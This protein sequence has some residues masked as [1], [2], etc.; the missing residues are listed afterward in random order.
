MVQNKKEKKKGNLDVAAHI[1]SKKKNNKKIKGQ[2]QLCESSG[3]AA[4]STCVSARKELLCIFKHA[5]DM[6]SVVSRLSP[7]FL[8][9]TK[10]QLRIRSGGG[11]KSISENTK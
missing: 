1:T 7:A 3:T 5:Y 11:A 9:R 8:P 4:N 10:S 6:L 2:S